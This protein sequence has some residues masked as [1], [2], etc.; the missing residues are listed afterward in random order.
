MKL[1]DLQLIIGWTVYGQTL[2]FGPITSLRAALMQMFIDHTLWDDFSLE[3]FYAVIHQ[4][5]A[6]QKDK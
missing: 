5:V 4:D 6:F 2:G 3:R 1:P